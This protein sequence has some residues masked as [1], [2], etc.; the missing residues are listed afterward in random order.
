MYSLDL[1]PNLIIQTDQESI[2]YPYFQELVD[3]DFKLSQYE[4]NYKLSSYKD[5]LVIASTRDRIAQRLVDLM[6]LAKVAIIIND[7]FNESEMDQYIDSYIADI[8]IPE[9]TFETETEKDALHQYLSIEAKASFFTDSIKQFFKSTIQ[10]DSKAVKKYIKK[11]PLLATK[12]TRITYKLITIDTTNMSHKQQKKLMKQ[13]QR[14][15]SIK[16]RLATV[17]HTEEQQNQA[18]LIETLPINVQK[19]VI[20]SRSKRTV[21]FSNKNNTISIL[22]VTSKDIDKTKKT[23]ILHTLAIDSYFTKWFANIKQT[24]ISKINANYVIQ[25]PNKINAVTD[26]IPPIQ[27]ESDTPLNQSPSFS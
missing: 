4:S 27:Y 15:P 24:T 19:Q 9:N 20:K 22:Y 25:A 8:P 11:N 10:L 5:Q 1:E 21:S 16:T 23:D 14:W 7:Q 26:I 12:W 3:T 18:V 13:Q 17:P 6:L 2:S